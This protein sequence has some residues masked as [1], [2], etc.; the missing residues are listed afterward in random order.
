MKERQRVCTHQSAAWVLARIHDVL[1]PPA[2][3]TGIPKP[4]GERDDT[5]PASRAQ[6]SSSSRALA[7]A[8]Q[9]TGVRAAA[10]RPAAALTSSPETAVRA[11]SVHLRRL[12]MYKNF[13]F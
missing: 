10:D 12:R 7:A 9:E 6:V 2:A 1:F 5:V 8:Q 4:Y 13:F 3:A 11:L